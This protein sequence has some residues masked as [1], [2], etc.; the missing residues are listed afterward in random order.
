[1]GSIY[2]GWIWWAGAV[3]LLVLL[4]RL[5]QMM[6]RDSGLTLKKRARARREQHHGMSAFP[7]SGLYG[8]AV[9]FDS[10][11]R[12]A[13]LASSSGEHST[14]PFCVSRFHAD[15][16]WLITKLLSESAGLQLLFYQVAN[17]TYM[18]QS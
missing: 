6:A 11:D 12:T 14:K 13:Q 4:A 10:E 15:S 2:R 3:L 1:M 16:F 5:G 7:P 8:N 18:V 9:V 17:L